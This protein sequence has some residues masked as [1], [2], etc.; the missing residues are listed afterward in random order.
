MNYKPV[1]HGRNRLNLSESAQRLFSDKRY[2]DNAQL[3][4]KKI[5]DQTVQRYVKWLVNM[6]YIVDQSNIDN[7]LSS[8]GDNFDSVVF[9]EKERIAENQRVLL[10]C[11]KKRVVERREQIEERQII[12]D[13]VVKRVSVTTERMM[14]ERLSEMTVEK[15]L[16]GFPEY[17]HFTAFAYSPSL[18]FSRLGTL[19]TLS[20]S[21]KNSVLDLVQND[22]FCHQLG[23]FP[24]H[25]SDPKVAIGYIG[26]ENCR[27]LFPVLMARPLLKWADKN[28]RAIAP[29]VWQYAVVM[30]NVTRMRLEDAGYKEP[31]EGV[32]IG[33][34]RAFSYFAVCNF[35]SQVSEDALVAVMKGYRD[36]EQNEEYF[37]CA[38]VKPTL[39]ILPSVLYKLD[40]IIM[41]KVIEHIDWGMRGTHLK[42]AL[43]EDIN[44]LP[45]LQRSLHGVALGQARAFSIYDMMKGSNAFVDKHAP[46]WFAN[47]Q[48]DGVSLKKVTARNPGR[49]TLSI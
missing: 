47:V 49:I 32:L 15:L 27:R 30:G 8:Q 7:V 36:E 26:I 6:K 24:K 38:E 12:M 34:V 41:T 48:M 3:V 35:F 37:A 45:I 16:S 4:A 1:E 46:Y 40:K 13:K 25:T 39:S 31:D 21:L 29:K 10:Q 18:S 17:G 11:E 28:T 9:E 5:T 22:N 42:N 19:T 2:E 23:K 20:N 44:D 43:L 14:T 33:V